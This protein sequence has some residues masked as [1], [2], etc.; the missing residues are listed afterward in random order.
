M[1]L[2]DTWNIKGRS[3]SCSITERKFED[4][5]SFYAAIFDAPDGEEGFV[6]RDFS[7]DAWKD[8][9]KKDNTPKPFSFWKSTYEAPVREE[10]EESVRKEDAESLLRRLVEEDEA[11]TENARFILAVMLERKKILK[12]TDSQRIGETK[13][14]IYEHRKSG[15]VLIIA[16]PQIPLDQV[17]NVQEE[18]ADLL[19][20]GKA[21]AAAEKLGM[22]PEAPTNTDDKSSTD[23]IEHAP[24]NEEI[25]QLVDVSEG[26]PETSVSAEHSAPEEDAKTATNH[27]D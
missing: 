7:I 20:G 8:H 22:T 9:E 11:H 10:K 24:Q 15:D 21:A 5:E 17:E 1:A 18:V 2:N 26:A 23:D 14:L 3:P 6:R 12:Q 25:T 19:A 16:D 4:G 27:R 13:L